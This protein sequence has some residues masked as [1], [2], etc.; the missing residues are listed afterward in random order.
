MQTTSTSMQDLM[1]EQ[2]ASNLYP[3]PDENLSFYSSSANSGNCRVIEEL[4][5]QLDSAKLQIETQ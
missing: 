3:I 2:V 4:Q 1:Q 5:D